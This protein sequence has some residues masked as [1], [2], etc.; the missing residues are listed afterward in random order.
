MEVLRQLTVA[1]IRLMNLY[2][3]E[4]VDVLKVLEFHTSPEGVQK[5]SGFCTNRRASQP[6]TAYRVGKAAQISAPTRQ[7]FP[8]GVF[9]E[10]FSIMTTIKPKSGLQSFLLSIYSERGVQQLGVEVGRSPVFLYEDQTGKPAPE[11]Y[12]LFRTLN[13]ADGKWHRV[14]ISVEKKTVTIIVDCK[15]KITKPLDRSDQ[16]ALDTNGITVFGSRILDEEVYETA[17]LTNHQHLS[18]SSCST[19]SSF[20]S[21]SYFSSFF[22]FSY[23]SSSFFSFSSCSTFSSFFSFSY[24]AFSSSSSFFSFS[25]FSFSSSFFSFSYF[26]FFSSSSSFSSFFFSFSYFSVS[27]SS[28]FSSFFSFSY[29]SFSSSFFSFSYFS[30][31]SSS[32][33]FSSFFFSFSYFSVSS[34]S[35]FSSFFSFSYFSFS[36]SFFSFSYFSFSSSSSSFFFFSFSYFSSFIPF[37]YLSF[38]SSSFFFSF[39]YFSF[40]FSS[41]TSSSFFSFSYLSFSSSSFFFSFSYFSFSSSS[42][43]SSFFSFSYFSFSYSSSFSS[44]FFSFSYFSFFSSSSSFSSFFFSFSYFSDVVPCREVVLADCPGPGDIQQ[45]LIVSDPKAAYDYCEH[46][47]PDCD[48]PHKDTLQAQ[49]PEE[50]ATGLE[51]GD[52]Y[53]YYDGATTTEPTTEVSDTKPN[54]IDDEYFTESELDYGTVDAPQTQSPVATTGRN[55]AV[56]EEIVGYSVKD[57]SQTGLDPTAG[58]EPTQPVVTGTDAYNFKEYDL[59]EYDVNELDKSQYEFGAY[60]E[61]GNVAPNPTPAY[62]DEFGR[63]VAAEKEV[64]ET[65]VGTDVSIT[66]GRQSKPG[67]SA[68]EQCVELHG[69]GFHGRAAAPEPT[70]PS[71]V[72]SVERSG[73]KLHP[74]TL[75]QNMQNMTAQNKLHKDM[76]ERVWCGGTGLACTES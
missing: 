17:S 65:Q 8:N 58:P 18:F 9:P 46:Y 76:E 62:E 72:Q 64:E 16:A 47:S 53:D 52:M 69:M 71:A 22:S 67:V 10:D 13:L 33:S 54:N 12:P 60:D 51:Y 32:S 41:S 59:E 68:Q 61:L 15:K 11:D 3:A 63:R 28:S 1:G 38:S 39:S 42:S 25:Y 50:Y 24:F 26:S 6:D 7:L 14:A 43:F 75:E 70:S 5:T 36:S 34:S 31:F 44:F 20:F 49:E 55:E 2:I 73:V 45:L 66:P 57:T 4:T 35:S 30:F 40:S 37:S 21:F 56:E 19:F 27:S 23:F 29:F 74:W 48:T